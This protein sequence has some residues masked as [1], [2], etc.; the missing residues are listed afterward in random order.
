M[1]TNI[2]Q[3][4]CRA[5]PKAERRLS[6]C[7]Y[8]DRGCCEQP[9]MMATPRTRAT[10]NV[11]LTQIWG[12]LSAAASQVMCASAVQWHEYSSRE[13]TGDPPLGVSLSAEPHGWTNPRVCHR[14]ASVFAHPAGQSWDWAVKVVLFNLCRRSPDILRRETQMRIIRL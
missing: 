10:T 4:S 13:I 12:C 5:T 3:W 6:C 1:H 2:G 9:S 7:R 14:E 8:K 11:R